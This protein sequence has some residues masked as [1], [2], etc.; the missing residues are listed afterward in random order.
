MKDCGGPG[1][2]NRYSDSLRTRVPRI[3]S[4]WGR[5]FPHSCTPTRGPTQSP[6]Q[7]A[8]AHSPGVNRRSASLTTHPHLVS[9]LKKE[10]SYNFTPPVRLRDL[11]Q[12]EFYLFT[13]VYMPQRTT[14]ISRMKFV[15]R[16][17]HLF[18]CLELCLLLLLLL[19]AF[20]THLRVL[21]SSF[22]RFR[23]HTQWCTTVGRTPLD[24][25][26]ARRRDLYLTNTQYSQQTNIH[27]PGGIRTRNPSKRAAADPRF[28]PLGHWDRL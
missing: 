19:L 25:W 24:E 17:W 11:F 7:G 27:A 8:W 1:Q 23:D 16:P 10:Y 22:L 9:R 3:E 4:R 28:R 12:G 2:L 13:K 14:L 15:F 26:S 6:I 18:S 20:T 5:D 21:A